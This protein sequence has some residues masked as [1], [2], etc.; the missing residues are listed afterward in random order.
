MKKYNR[1]LNLQ[2]LIISL[3]T[4]F[5][6]VMLA[7][8]IWASYQVQRQ[9]LIDNTLEANQAYANKLGQITQN[10]VLSTQQQLAYSARNIGR[11]IYRTSTFKEE[12][13]RLREQS[14]SFNS[15]IVVDAAGV[16]RATSPEILEIVGKV[17][18]S[19]ANNEALE[20]RSPVV[21]DPFLSATG[22]LVVTISHP[23]FTENKKYEGYITASI[24]LKEMNVLYS[25][26]GTH[27]Y[28]DGSYL[29]VVGQDGKLLYHPESTRIGESAIRNEAVRAVSEGQSGALHT[30]NSHGIEMLAGFA[31]VPAVGWGI[32]AQRPL[33]V[34]LAPLGQLMS[35]MLWNA[36]PLG[37]LSLVLIWLFSRSI[38]MPLWQLAKNAET[39]DVGEAISQVKAVNSWYFEAAQ[40][41]KA[42][43]VSFRTLSERIG[44][45]DIA[46]LTDPMTQLTNRRGLERALNQFERSGKPFGII[47]FDMDNFKSINDRYGHTT[48]DQVIVELAHCM[49]ANARPQ[50]IL[51]RFGG[52]EF[53]MLLPEIDADAVL[54]VAER[55]RKAIESHVFPSVGN[56]TI[57][58]GVSHYPETEDDPDR[59]IGQADKALYLAKSQG[60]NRVASYQKYNQTSL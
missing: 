7:N 33:S 20:H 18:T 57:S 31:P 52:D 37:I 39:G 35:T 25:L 42:V 19:A 6:L 24:Y 10:F 3:T 38:S 50:D 2:R 46:T 11:N 23:I 13:D 43:L 17:L 44:E 21:S 49:R 16:V 12:A 54:V 26:L 55:L 32:V 53:L 4:L 28:R 40:L 1:Y 47:A 60:R 27:F 29:Y 5:T 51:C 36:A 30:I 15:V 41:K 9:Q 56:V 58:A 34:T 59:A 48:G 22:K 14:D 8:A 45:L